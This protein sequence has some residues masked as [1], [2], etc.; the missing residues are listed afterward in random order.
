MNRSDLRIDRAQAARHLAALDLPGTR[1]IFA[2]IP[3]AASSK[4]P[5]F[6]VRHVYG[7]LAEVAKQLDIAQQEGCAVYVT[8]Q[9]MQGRRR[10]KAEVTRIRAV[11]CERDAPGK[12][13]PLPPSLRNRSSPGKGHE[14]LLCDPS[15]PLTFDEAE[16]INTQIVTDFGG[17]PNARDMARVL[18][19]AGSWHLKGE[20]HR[21]EIIGGTGE[22]YTRKALLA[23][24]PAPPPKR[25]PVRPSQIDVSD[26][27]IAGTARRLAD[28]IARSG[29]GSRNAQLNKAA[30]RLGQLGVQISLATALLEP[31]AE[32][33]GLPAWE[34]K[35]TIASG[36][37]AGS[38]KMAPP[39]AG[40][41]QGGHR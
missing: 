25:R 20:P 7:S 29:Q 9:A 37:K 35:R 36:W 39:D 8:V 21:V 16:R 26:R 10:L 32:L 41:Q 1:F 11:W 3:E 22:A 2:L 27:Y 15:D 24:F 33:V 19:L 28:E 38:A 13:L 14:F 23:A 31:S 5:K 40:A 18:R 12:A 34:I 6:R 4:H 30:F 17:D